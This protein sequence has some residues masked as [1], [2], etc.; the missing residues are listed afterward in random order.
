MQPDAF[1]G[2][3]QLQKLNMSANKIRTLPDTLFVPLRSLKNI[4]LHQNEINQQI[5]LSILGTLRNLVVLDM[6]SNLISNITG[7][8]PR[9]STLQQVSFDGNNLTDFGNIFGSSHRL[10][11]ISVQNNQISCLTQKAF[12]GSQNLKYLDISPNNI[13]KLPP[14]V[15][16]DNSNLRLINMSYNYLQRLSSKLF[17]GLRSEERRVERV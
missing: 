5:N 6:A 2:L 10:T 8:F 4:S 16:V 14:N 1:I 9:P 3:H 11:C 12:S 17:Y 15:F 7:S 13:T